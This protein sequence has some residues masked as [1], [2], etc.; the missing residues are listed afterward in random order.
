MDKFYVYE[1]WRKETSESYYGKCSNFK[2]RM[3]DHKRAGEPTSKLHKAIKKYGWDAFDHRIV[4]EF[5]DEDK[6]F[7]HEEYLIKTFNTQKTG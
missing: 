6:A 1:V 3:S 5:D 2:K 7:E 4:A